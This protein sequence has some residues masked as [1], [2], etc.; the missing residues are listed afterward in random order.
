M[1]QLPI[2]LD[3]GP[4]TITTTDRCWASNYGRNGAGPLL[5]GH[6]GAAQTFQQ[7]GVGQ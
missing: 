6:P 5:S 1:A 7:L 2:A 4:T 3:T